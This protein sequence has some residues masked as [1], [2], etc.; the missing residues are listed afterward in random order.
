MIG[1]IQQGVMDNAVIT[2]CYVPIV[3]GVSSVVLMMMLWGNLEL[4]LAFTSLRI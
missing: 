3:T 2:Y 4:S 1:V